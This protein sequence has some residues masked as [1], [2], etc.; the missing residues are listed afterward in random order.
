M[1]TL[2]LIIT[3]LF[4]FMFSV[5]SFA[6]AWEEI[7][8]E[9][10]KTE[11]GVTLSIYHYPP[12]NPIDN[13]PP[14]IACPGICTDHYFYDPKI[15][16]SLSRLTQK[17]GFD[18]WSLE[19]R[20]YGQSQKPKGGFW[21]FGKWTQTI[22]SYIQFDV[23]AAVNFVKLKTGA[24][25]VFWV[26]HSRGG[27]IGYGYMTEKKQ[28]DFAG[29]VMLA[30]A[31][32]FSTDSLAMKAAFLGGIYRNIIFDD[33]MLLPL[34]QI[35]KVISYLPG[36]SF[37]YR[38]PLLNMIYNPHNIEKPVIKL[39]HREMLQ[40]IPTNVLKQFLLTANKEELVGFE[41]NYSYTAQYHKI[42][43]PLLCI[44]GGGDKLVSVQAVQAFFPD[45]SSVD[46][47]HIILSEE[48]GFV[49]EYG[50][51]DMLLGTHAEKEVYPIISDWLERR[52]DLGSKR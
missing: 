32:R 27:A 42:T 25:Q 18:V 7:E 22:D 21:A 15:G 38:T 13:A 16:P 52:V 41:S 11:D 51:A 17:K 40:S 2:F 8:P 29:A 10:F 35:S 50:H 44:T 28:D 46:K 47:T 12:A 19:V 45:V 24:S 37:L 20:G 26:G 48:N 43:R 6:S 4:L 9:F 33:N 49:A 1:R 3:V 31:G 34:R 23:P 30:G 39:F 5:Q 36:Q 14:V